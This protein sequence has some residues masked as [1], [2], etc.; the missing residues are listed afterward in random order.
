M[1]V[2]FVTDYPDFLG[3]ADD[4]VVDN[5]ECAASDAVGFYAVEVAV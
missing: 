1:E 4:A 2:D 5:A 3:A